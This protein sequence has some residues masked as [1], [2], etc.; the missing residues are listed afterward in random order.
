MQTRHRMTPRCLRL[1][2]PFAALWLAACGD[3][4]SGQGT[5]GSHV[6]D[7][8][9]CER[10][11]AVLDDLLVHPM[12]CTRTLDCPVG[13][14]CRAET[15]TC[16]WS[17]YSDSDCGLGT[18]D[19]DGVCQAPGDAGVP[20]P[21]IEAACPR[22][23]DRL[24][25]LATT[26][27]ACALDDDCPYGAHCDPSG[28]CAASCTDDAGCG[29]DESC[30][31]KGRC[32]PDDADPLAAAP[33][34]RIE[35]SP[36]VIVM[37]QFVDGTWRERAIEVQLI[38]P[39]GVVPGSGFAVQ[40]SAPELRIGCESS[41]SGIA[42]CHLTSWTFPVGS[43]R[44]A[45]KRVFV[46]PPTGATGDL[47][48]NLRLTAPEA[49]TSVAIATRTAAE[50]NVPYQPLGG[51]YT[52]TVDRLDAQGA[53]VSRVGVDAW[54]IEVAGNNYIE[55]HDPIGSV[56]YGGK[57]VMVAGAG[58][59]NRWLGSDAGAIDVEVNADTLAHEPWVGTAFGGFVVRMPGGAGSL[60]YRL[61]LNRTGAAATCDGG[62]A[63]GTTCSQYF[64]VCTGGEPW[65][66]HN[67]DNT[68]SD[69]AGGPWVSHLETLT[70]YTAGGHEL[71]L[72]SGIP[73][74]SPRGRFQGYLGL[75][76]DQTSGTAWTIYDGTTGVASPSLA[77][78]RAIAT[79]HLLARDP[80]VSWEPEPSTWAPPPPHDRGRDLCRQGFDPYIGWI[81]TQQGFSA[82]QLYRWRGASS[83]AAMC[84]QLYASNFSYTG[85]AFDELIPC[86]DSRNYF[87][88]TTNGA[89]D[90]LPAGREGGCGGLARNHTAAT[91]TVESY[92]DFVAN[93]C[94]ASDYVLLTDGP[95]HDEFN[96]VLLCPWKPALLGPLD[97]RASAER[98]M[99]AR[100]EDPSI[101]LTSSRFGTA[102]LPVSGDLACA[103]GEAPHGVELAHLADQGDPIGVGGLAD[104]CLDEL[105]AQP[106][107]EQD[108]GDLFQRE[109]Q[110]AAY[111]DTFS[112]GQ[113]F[114]PAVFYPA[115]D[116]LIGARGADDASGR[117]LQRV[118]Q[119]WLALHGFLAR[120]GIDQDP[121]V[122]ALH[123]GAGA[124]TTTLPD[125]E[126]I[127][128]QVERGWT[129]LEDRDVVAAIAR[130]SS[131][132]LTSPDY[133]GVAA[134]ADDEQPHGLAVPLVDTA[135]LHVEL[136]VRAATAAQLGAYD[137]CR[138]GG[139]SWIAEAML[140]RIGSGLRHAATAEALAMSLSAR[141][142]GAPWATKLASSLDQLVAV[143]A[144]LV[145]RGTDLATCRHPLGI[146]EDQVPLYFGDVSGDSSRFFAASD[147]LMEAWASP[148]VAQAD[149]ALS[150]ARNAWL[151][152]RQ[153]AIQDIATAQDA[154]RRLD[155]L[156]AGYGRDVV[157]LCG[158]E[159]V[160]AGQA[161]DYV[162]DGPGQLPVEGCHLDQAPACAVSVRERFAAI[163][164]DHVRF[165][166]CLWANMDPFEGI[167]TAAERQ[168]GANFTSATA[169]PDGGRYTVSGQ[170]F[171]LEE[172]YAKSLAIAESPRHHVAVV[173]CSAQLR[174]T[175]EDLP[176]PVVPPASCQ[177]GQLG[178]ASLGVVAAQRDVEVAVS[179]WS[180][181][182][183]LLRIS[184]QRCIDVQDVDEDVQFL[185]EA[186]AARMIDL[187]R[188]LYRARKTSAGLG[189]FQGVVGMVVSSLA[190]DPIGFLG[191]ASTVIN[192]GIANTTAR[193]ERDLA[194]AQ[195]SHA[196]EISERS[197]Q[198][199]IRNC[200]REVDATSVTIDTA[201]AE[202]VSALA[203]ADIAMQQFRAGQ[204]RLRQTLLEGRAAVAREA[205]RVVPP[206]A[207]HYWLDEELTRYSDDFE[208]SR[209]LTYLAMLAVEHEFQA[210]L[211]LRGDILAATHP[212]HLAAALRSLEQL[213]L[214]RTI[215]ARRPEEGSLVLSLRD[216][217]LALDDRVALVPGDRDLTAI[218]LLQE[219]LVDEELAVHGA[220]GTYLGQGI[221]FTLRPQGPLRMRCAERLWRVTA[222]IQGDLLDV[223]APSA[224][225]VLVKRAHAQS[226]WCE[227]LGDGTAFQDGSL[228]PTS[229][230]FPADEH[231][232]AAA[233]GISQVSAMLE[234]YYN[235]PRSELYADAYTEG[236]SEELAGQGLY[237][238]YMLL[239]PRYGLLEDGFP[240]DD[241]EDVLVRFD[242]LS[243]DDL[244]DL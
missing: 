170:T 152:Q 65:E 49:S 241:V 26:P 7:A 92:A 143:R 64:G 207:F 24:A 66:W 37:N 82:S 30:D 155:Q 21:T 209:T 171:P 175:L 111:E 121:V 69:P 5:S 164:D 144:E 177:R 151:S 100:A 57:L 172:L 234:P 192:G 186:H 216:D 87:G 224:H 158:L 184:S 221:P 183:D 54:I 128:D 189:I 73:N 137:Q 94:V 203:R 38:A 129:L 230:L 91:G 226:Q 116:E 135:M 103:D 85:N 28:Q 187:Q 179:R 59:T 134:G 243:I 25:G 8:G 212:D 222:T 2:V 113:C 6:N 124:D 125:L 202:V 89:H 136:L 23:L 173:T 127:L 167:V 180:D 150:T 32:V 104:I 110:V 118:L 107:R 215:N 80:P 74:F 15:S 229:Q 39:A 228:L 78:H 75:Y 231:G 195:E 132:A 105:G 20:D 193:L 62:C 90:Q 44:S 4:D 11:Q 159:Q 219:R 161:L 108:L 36:E 213:R 81:S 236:G 3:P 196:A 218:E 120:G 35:A 214:G 197:T 83:T 112:P 130:L 190:S 84:E 76:T 18:C 122:R 162:G 168:R 148:A 156:A 98:L 117:L 22:N 102:K 178:E 48:W 119:Q 55:I 239:L 235:V 40:V 88:G 1:L 97:G 109:V 13:A 10:D 211:D 147:Y 9:V 46:Q 115:L 56:G 19:C 34:W 61:L 185:I 71:D 33:A 169:Q 29:T 43:N 67:E 176:A 244:E 42:P 160:E 131:G 47:S 86:V 123:A 206:L 174:Y 68:T 232:G 198:L 140:A 63:A 204:A 70:G 114:T 154:D 72:P 27:E 237:G 188:A 139:S 16:D 60:S 194:I 99:C 31:C 238:E 163:T 165:Q 223:E 41:A 225:I 146:S 201:A 181:A 58:I 199:E 142:V 52:G 138:G 79:A 101:T 166:M 96:L 205:G 93:R 149:D 242:H 133:R 233:E 217:L 95:I 200:W 208:W 53:L 17:C 12:T 51:A 126:R 141:A 145:R 191:S 240:L 153:A 210:T 50:Q 77:T 220:D 106:P 14:F 227:G 157:S 45:R 182:Q